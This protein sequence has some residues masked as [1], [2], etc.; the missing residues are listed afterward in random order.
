MA[1]YVGHA[2]NPA[3]H[4]RINDNSVSR[5]HLEVSQID[6]DTLQIIDLGST[7][8]T[9]IDEIEI[10]ESTLRRHQSIRI[11]HQNY[12]GND[13]FEKVRRF[14]LDRRVYWIDE[15]ASLE[16]KFKEFEDKK[17]KL[18]QK[19]QLKMAIIRGVLSIAISF[20][21][22]FLSGTSEFKFITSVGG[23]ILAGT[24]VPYLI[25]KEKTTDKMHDLNKKYAKILACP[26]C[27]RDL[28]RYNFRL[29][30]EEK[31]CSSCDAIWVQ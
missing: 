26:R 14:F 23:G 31:R 5:R 10:V 7:N 6:N 30:K 19:L 9:W 3:N 27:H 24:L 16:L 8:G 20:L 2:S 13:F 18:N 28:S 22:Y 21:F 17:A 25:S 12:S 1:I 29:L 11:G 15:F 4:V